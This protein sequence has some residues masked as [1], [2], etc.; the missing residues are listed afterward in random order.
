[1]N[2]REFLRAGAQLAVGL[3]TVGL[4]FDEPECLDLPDLDLEG[5]I[6][7][8]AREAFCRGEASHML[9]GDTTPDGGFLVPKDLA[10]EIL[11]LTGELNRVYRHTVSVP[12]SKIRRLD[13]EPESESV[14]E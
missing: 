11:R 7:A 3:A 13:R 5:L 2:R 4:P 12:V 1:M 8:D 14:P 6:A 10:D 9:T